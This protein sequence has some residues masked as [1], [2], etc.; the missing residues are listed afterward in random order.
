MTVNGFDSPKLFGMLL[1]LLTGN[2]WELSLSTS[3][4]STIAIH[5]DN[6]ITLYFEVT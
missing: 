1:V 4:R 6:Q 2:E 3:G 5:L